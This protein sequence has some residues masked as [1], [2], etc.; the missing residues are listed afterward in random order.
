MNSKSIEQFGVGKNLRVLLAIPTFEPSYEKSPDLESF[1]R[2]NFDS[3][4]DPEGGHQLTLVLTDFMS[5]AAFKDFLREYVES[6]E[7]KAVLIDGRQRLGAYQAANVAYRAFEYDMAAFAESDTRA[8]DRGWLTQLLKDFQDDQV[9]AAFATTP[10]DGSPVIGQTQPNCIDKAS[11]R[12][13]FPR[14][15]VP[16]LSVFRGSFL[17]QFDCRFSDVF[18]NGGCEEGLI[19]QIRAVQGQAMLNYRCN[20]LHNRRFNDGRY[21]RTKAAHWS[22]QLRDEER[23]KRLA[24]QAWLSVPN[25]L[26]RPAFEPVIRPIVAGWQQRR[27][28]GVLV[29]V[30]VRILKTTPFFIR[31]EIRRRGLWGYLSQYLTAKNQAR[32]FDRLPERVR[33]GMVMALY[34]CAPETYQSLE[35]EIVGTSEHP[36]RKGSCLSAKGNA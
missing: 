26:L 32:R 2:E 29:A 24:I 4:L 31:N 7:G 25:T 30:Y 23:E 22:F 10:V 33:I 27:L 9:V 12:I 20:V 19:W 18:V 14:G 35:F 8:R 36:M 17:E 28:R 34:G 11:A 21:D 13:P 16:I 1:Y 5:S 3:Y 15:G 6:R